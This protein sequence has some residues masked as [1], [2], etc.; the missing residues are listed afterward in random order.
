MHRYELVPRQEILVIRDSEHAEA[1]LRTG[2]LGADVSDDA[3]REAA[4][5]LARGE[6]FLRRSR[7]RIPLDPPDRSAMALL[8]GGRDG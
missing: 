2:A 5:A 1:V 3:V 6:V 7:A 8:S 4:Q